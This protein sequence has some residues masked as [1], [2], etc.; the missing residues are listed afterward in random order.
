MFVSSYMTNY[1]GFCVFYGFIFGVGA[2]IS[3]MVPFN[4]AYKYFP[5]KKGVIS[6]TLSAGFG[7]GSLVMSF[8]AFYLI[9]PDNEEVIDVPGAK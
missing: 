1:T 9:N 8:L 2:G 7:I 3:Y 6:G 4:N 5:E